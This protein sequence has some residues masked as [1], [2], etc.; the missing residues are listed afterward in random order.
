MKTL[1]LVMFIL[2]LPYTE[3]FVY[4]GSSMRPPE[5]GELVGLPYT[6]K[7]YSGVV[8]KNTPVTVTVRFPSWVSHA[9][10]LLKSRRSG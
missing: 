4:Y 2:G 1:R 3:T 5:D 8:V 10:G 7:W 9:F 6:G